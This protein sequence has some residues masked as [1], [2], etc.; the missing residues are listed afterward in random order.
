MLL[1]RLA[2]AV[3]HSLIRQNY[4]CTHFILG[5]DHA[6]PGS[7]SK[8]VDFYGPF[9]ARDYALSF[10]A[11]LG[12]KLCPFDMMVYLPGEQRYVGEREVAPGTRVEKLSGT[13]V[14]KRL[15]QGTEIP[16]SGGARHGRGAE[17]HA[18]TIPLRL[19][20]IWNTC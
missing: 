11:E 8:G 10:Q 12:I 1:P 6:G 20:P 15:N 4:G 3:W 2:E 13:E 7:N 9:D 19:R 14:R 17:A 18:H 5:R 16:V